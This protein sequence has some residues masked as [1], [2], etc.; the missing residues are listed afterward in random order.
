M[1]SVSLCRALIAVQLLLCVLYPLGQAIEVAQIVS[2]DA[3]DQTRAGAEDA[4]PK[5]ACQ[6]T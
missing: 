2:P 6:V 3:I 5:K 4:G 1:T